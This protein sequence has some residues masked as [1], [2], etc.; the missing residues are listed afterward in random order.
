ML[1]AAAGAAAGALAVY[2]LTTPEGRRLF[3]AAI[4]VLDDFSV[5]CARFSQACTRAHIAAAE[6]WQTV[7]GSTTSTGGE[8][9]TVF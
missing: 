5:E 7:K 2:I 8:R 1:A 4:G 3:N 9:E 6:S